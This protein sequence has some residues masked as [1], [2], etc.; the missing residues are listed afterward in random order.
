MLEFTGNLQLFAL[1][2]AMDILKINYLWN[3]NFFRRFLHHLQN[4]NYNPNKIPFIKFVNNILTQQ[5]IEYL[6]TIASSDDNTNTKP[7]GS[8]HPNDEINKTKDRSSLNNKNKFL[9]YQIGGQ[10]SK[11]SSKYYN[12]FDKETQL[13]LDEIGDRLKPKFEKL[14]DK[15]LFLGESDF[16]CCM[17]RYEG[18]DA[19]FRFHYD[20]EEKNCYRSIIMFHGKGNIPPFMYYDKN[21]NLIKKNLK[22]G[23]GLIFQGTRTYHGIQPSNDEEMERYVIGWQ[24]STD[25]SVKTKSICAELRGKSIME[26]IRT[27]VPHFLL[28]T[29]MIFMFNKLVDG[30]DGD[31]IWM[32]KLE[33]LLVITFIVSLVNC[34]FV[35]YFPSYL[36]TG[37]Y[38]WPMQQLSLLT[39]CMLSSFLNPMD[40]LVLYNYILLTEMF[41]PRRIIG[42]SLRFIGG[43]V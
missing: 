35:H 21:G 34:K 38:S 3:E 27:I 4:S 20:T 18:K 26:G 43:G 6:K 10:Y 39:I 33:Y 8:K 5:D 16:R 9:S 23:D 29:V 24:Y 2:I 25:L 31:S 19:N 7:S 17:L 15:K 22:I 13:K 14:I 30:G 36:G 37:L 1:F 42:K 28:S 32:I 41:L 11:R 40:G 12:N